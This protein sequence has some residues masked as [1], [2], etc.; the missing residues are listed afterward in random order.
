M[1]SFTTSD[2]A[3]A[4]Y[5]LTFGLKL[6]E[7]KKLPDGRFHFELEDKDGKSQQLSM[8]F[9][10]SDFCKFDNNIKMLKKLLYSR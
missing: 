10:N 8:D 9:I 7:A 1:N 6:V 2:L 5:L 3:L 4:G